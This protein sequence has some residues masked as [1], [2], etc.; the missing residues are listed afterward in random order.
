MNLRGHGRG[1]CEVLERGAGGLRSILISKKLATKKNERFSL[2]FRSSFDPTKLISVWDEKWKSDFSPPVC[3]YLVLLGQL[4]KEAFFPPG[5]I[6]SRV[7]GYSF[8]DL[9]LGTL[10][11]ILGLCVCLLSQHYRF[12]LLLCLCGII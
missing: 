5:M 7:S 10:V 9:I 2:S 8:I 1:T 11:F 3:G 4:V 12:F 6:L